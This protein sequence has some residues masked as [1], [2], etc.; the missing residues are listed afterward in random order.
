MTED[1]TGFSE[2]EEI[3]MLLP[4]YVSGTLDATDSD[5]VERYLARHPEIRRQLDLIRD[6]RQEAILANEALPV[7]R[8]G[9]L[10]RLMASLPVRRP[11]L[12]ER[13]TRLQAFQALADFFAAPTPR[14]VRYAAVAAAALVLVQAA[15][16]SVLLIRGDGTG[17]VTASGQDSG[18]GLAFFVSFKDD[19]SASAISRFL[20]EVDGRIVDGPKPGAVFKVRVRTADRSSAAAD[21]LQQRLAERRDLV[22]LVMP[23]KD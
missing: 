9:A 22:R 2:R 1:R 14:A 15:A 5:R 6:E 7:S 23:A 20:T 18:E 4:W 19:A 11:G 13:L 21:A 17:Y 3:E 16:L 8:A 10:D 12:A